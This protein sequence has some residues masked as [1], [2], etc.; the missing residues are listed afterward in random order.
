MMMM[1]TAQT[2]SLQPGLAHLPKPLR[3][4]PQLMATELGSNRLVQVGIQLVT[5]KAA[6]AKMACPARHGKCSNQPLEQNPLPSQ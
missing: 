1:I 3:K 2:T 5:V 4:R 6:C